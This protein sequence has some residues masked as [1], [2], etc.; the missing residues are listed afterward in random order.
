M[1]QPCPLERPASP[2]KETILVIS[3]L[4]PATRKTSKLKG[5]SMTRVM[6]LSACATLCL[7]LFAMPSNP[8]NGKSAAKPLRTSAAQKFAELSDQFMKD[9]LALSPTNASQAGYHKHLDSKT[10]KT[11]ELDALLDDMSLKSMAEQ[12][13]FYQKWRDRFH[14]ETPAAALSPEDAADWQLI[15]DQIGLNLLEFD[16]IQNY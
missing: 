4:F 11:I 14:R 10:G 12:R 1:H 9:S 16:K 6:A 3:R 5:I 7:V 15:E 8:Q 13:A 2:L